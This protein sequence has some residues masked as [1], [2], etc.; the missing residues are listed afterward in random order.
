MDISLLRSTIFRFTHIAI[1]LAIVF[2]FQKANAQTV[3]LPGDIVI[4]TANAGNNSVDFIPLIDI[5]KNTTLYFSD[6]LWNSE[7]QELSGNE[8]IITFN[9]PVTAGTNLHINQKRDDR[10][11]VSGKLKLEGKTH[12]LFSYQKE[13]GTYRFIYAVGWGQPGIWNS[14]NPESSD[15]PDNLSKGNK[16]LLTLGDADN[17]QY[18]IRNGASGTRN[19]LLKFVDDSANWRGRNKKTYPTFGT[20]F[21]LLKPPVVLFDNSVSTVNEGDNTA[22]L[23]VAIYEHDGSKLTVDVVYDSLRS[24]TDRND[25]DSFKASTI[26]FTGLI[27]NGVYEIEVPVVDDD[28][29]EGTETGIFTLENLSKG[30]FGD[31]LTH[32]LIINDDELPNVQISRVLNSSNLNNYIELK[33]LENRAV[34]LSG[35]SI[36]NGNNK[37]TFDRNTVLS[38]EDSLRLIEET[39]PDTKAIIGNTL[40]TDLKG[41]LLNKNGGELILSSYSGEIINRVE[42]PRAQKQNETVYDEQVIVSSDSDQLNNTDTFGEAISSRESYLKSEVPGWKAFPNHQDILSHYQGV[43]FYT[44]SEK[45]QKF[46]NIKP[47]EL[48][49]DVEVVFAYF[50]QKIISDYKEVPETA[51]AKRKAATTLEIKLSA[52]D[53][54]ENGI[55]D[56]L[57][58]LNPAI[59]NL[60]NN[61][62]VHS[63]ISEL[64]GNNTEDAFN[65]ILYSI[66]QGETGEVKYIQLQPE[67]EIIPGSAFWILLNNPQEKSLFSINEDQLSSTEREENF[68]EELASKIELEISKEGFSENIGISFQHEEGDSVHIKNLNSYSGSSFPFQRFLNLSI[69]YGNEYFSKMN[70]PADVSQSLSFPLSFSTSESGTFKIKITDWEEIPKDWRISLEDHKTGNKYNLR[71]DFTLNFNYDTKTKV[72]E[73]EDVLPVVDLYEKNDRF[74]LHI[75]PPQKQQELNNISDLPKEIDLHQNFPNPFNPLTTIS[76]YIPEPGEVTLSVFNIV[77]QP[78]SVIVE[79]NLSAGQHQFD[80]DANDR[81]S[82]MYIYQLEVGNKILTRKMTLVK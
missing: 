55:I 78:V 11:D 63:L 68:S 39:V 15:Q 69:N 17:Y 52:S 79:G 59:N 57:E 67:D 74:T 61:V 3:L 56:G 28:L 36:S 49:D 48:N 80:W 60:N 66:R 45:N 7:K 27:G 46:E 13:E 32:S 77:G 26:N 10:F 50:D 38:P 25:F 37:I 8:I 23:N 18:Y 81:P 31:F 53:K 2:S 14:D 70:F 73:S 33:N 24:I 65:P 43:D 30:N 54:N 4:V 82:G 16:T 12:H 19:M 42:Y 6:G 29:Y 21:N 71:N 40:L 9:S 22:Y 72:K 20:S 76:F 62:R 75:Q 35:W 44:W 64:K 5:E 51:R 34:S 58:G 41:K 47:S 1:F